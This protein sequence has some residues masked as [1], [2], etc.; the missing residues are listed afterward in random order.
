MNSRPTDVVVVVS[1]WPGAREGA[2][3]GTSA[4]PRRHERRVVLV[5]DDRQLPEIAAGGV[6]TAPARRPPAIELTTTAAN[7]LAAGLSNAE[8]AHAHCQ[9]DSDQARDMA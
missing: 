1:C 6:F 3:G 5:G 2:V 9:E 8:I 4:E 7:M